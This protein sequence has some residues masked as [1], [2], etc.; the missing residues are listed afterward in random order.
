MG[1]GQ[2]ERFPLRLTTGC[3]K[4]VPFLFLNIYLRVYVRG[5]RPGRGGRVPQAGPVA[6]VE[7]DVG[8]HPV[9]LRPAAESQTESQTRSHCRTQSRPPQCSCP[10]GARMLRPMEATRHFPVL[11]HASLPLCILAKVPSMTCQ[12]LGGPCQPLSARRLVSA[13]C[14]QTRSGG[15]VD[16]SLLPGS[17]PLPDSGPWRVFLLGAHFPHNLYV[18][19]LL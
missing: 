7:P 2:G 17:L 12:A 8:R 1:Q 18:W 3:A 14:P 9:T 13:L 19:Y 16:F 10:C 11:S 6:S 15:C 5:G 4:A